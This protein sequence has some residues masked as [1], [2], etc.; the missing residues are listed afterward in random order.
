[1]LDKPKIHNTC[2]HPCNR[3]N[4]RLYTVKRKHSTM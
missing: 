3:G 2:Y 1:M 4:V